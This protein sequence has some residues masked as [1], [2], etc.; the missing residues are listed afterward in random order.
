MWWLWTQYYKTIM[1]SLLLLR[2]VYIN[3]NI[4]LSSLFPESVNYKISFKRVKTCM[5]KLTP[6][7]VLVFLCSNCSQSARWS[8]M[9]AFTGK[10][11]P[12][13]YSCTLQV[14]KIKPVVWIKVSVPL[15]FRC[16]SFM[17][18]KWKCIFEQPPSCLSG[19]KWN[20]SEFR[21]PGWWAK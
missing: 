14:I 20:P 19:K 7:S 6:M 15:T 10:F 13:L 8:C 12:F 11:L 3:D 4:W 2:N 18:E 9:K 21:Q 17:Q 5:H 1:H 16:K